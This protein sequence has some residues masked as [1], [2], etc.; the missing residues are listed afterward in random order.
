MKKFLPFAILGV[1]IL[2]LVG[3]FFITRNK[4]EIPQE[5]ETA[6]EIPFEMR[7]VASLTP[8]ED[9][10]WLTMKIEKINIEAATVDYLILYSLPDGRS[11]G[12]PGT[13][14][15]QKGETI[16]RKLLLGSESS[17]KFRYD[18]GV[19]QGTLSFK[20]R[21]D[22]GKLVGKLSTEFHLQSK[23]KE[24]TSID[25]QFK[26]T[27]DKTPT[28]DFFVTM[29]TFGA[30][31]TLPSMSKGPYGVFSSSLVKLSGVVDIEGEIYS[32]VDNKWTK[33]D[34]GKSSNLGIFASVNPQ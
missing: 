3:A 4:K 31:E 24:L 6:P 12:V 21:D 2:I 32:W 17:G 23:V 29:Q 34:A 30:F 7:P 22:K 8:T 13:V 20:F 19:S 15:I 1:G 14:K 10:H 5:E 9:G 28:K 26:F 33:L 11:Q 16:E 27:L 25:N 18:E